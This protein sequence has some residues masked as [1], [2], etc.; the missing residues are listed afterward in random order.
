MQTMIP[1]ALRKVCLIRETQTTAGCRRRRQ[2]FDR[3][4]PHG[5]I[6]QEGIEVVP[7]GDTRRDGYARPH[8]C[9]FHPRGGA[10]TRGLN[11]E[12]ESPFVPANIHMQSLV[13]VCISTRQ[14]IYN[15]NI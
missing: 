15:H 6:I 9:D 10:P 3:T 4:I 2:D 7:R 5:Q 13:S 12:L 8:R 1:V 11:P 14:F